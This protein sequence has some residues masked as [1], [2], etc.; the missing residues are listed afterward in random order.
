MHLQME[1]DLGDVTSPECWRAADVLMERTKDTPHT[2]GLQTA[3]QWPLAPKERALP[4]SPSETVQ[5]WTRQAEKPP[6]SLSA[7]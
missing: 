1:H 4:S 3:V 7:A 5:T 2:Q 6:V